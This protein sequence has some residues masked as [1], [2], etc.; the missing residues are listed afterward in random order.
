MLPLYYIADATLTLLRRIAKRE[1]FWQAHRAHF[2]Q[3]ATDRGLSVSEIVARV[4]AINLA[5]SA[6]LRERACGPA[7]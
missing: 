6:R 2:Y 4:F 1:P 5:L 7:R 3:R